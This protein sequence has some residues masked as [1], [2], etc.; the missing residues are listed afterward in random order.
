[1]RYFIVLLFLIF[2]PSV[3]LANQ[4]ICEGNQIIDHKQNNKV[5][6]LNAFMIVTLKSQNGNEQTWC[7]SYKCVKIKLSD[8]E[9]TLYEKGFISPA[10]IEEQSIKINKHNFYFE[11]KQKTIFNGKIN[12][13]LTTS[14]KCKTE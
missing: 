6:D 12:T 8:D 3:L 5:F 2:K 4:L 14:G 10:M 7:G 13:H 9:I 11:L 1:M